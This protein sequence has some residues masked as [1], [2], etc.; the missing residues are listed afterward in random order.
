ME[1]LATYQF[2]WKSRSRAGSDHCRYTSR[3]LLNTALQRGWLEGLRED[4]SFESYENILLL[5]IFISSHVPDLLD[6]TGYCG[7]TGR[8][9]LV[10]GFEYCF[11]KRT[12]GFCFCLYYCVRLF[13]AFFSGM[14]NLYGTRQ[15]E[16]ISVCDMLS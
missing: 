5:Y 12:C 3:Y 1:H 10:G 9:L 7:S 8:S 11:N 2:L 6:L 14:G 4:T 13:S 15:V 16:I